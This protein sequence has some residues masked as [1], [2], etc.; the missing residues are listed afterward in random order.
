MPAQRMNQY[1]HE[2]SGGMKQRVMIAM[3]LACDPKLL[4]C[5]EPT[6][7]LDVTIQKQIL[8][9]IMRLQ[10]RA[11][12]GRALHHARPG[13]DRGDHRHRG[14][15]VSGRDAPEV[16]RGHGHGERA[17]LRPR[18]PHRRVRKRPAASSRTRSTPT[19]RVWCAAARRSSRAR[20]ACRRS[21]TSCGPRSRASPSTPA[22]RTSNIDYPGKADDASARTSPA[23]ARPLLELKDV[24]TW[25]PIQAGVFQR[26]VDWVKAVDGVDLDDHP[27]A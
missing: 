10:K 3:A 19:P 26:T 7:A 5:D 27:R 8:D 13:R 22:I 2:L 4:I 12:H 16:L 17:G 15:H 18:R 24:R 14:G 9:L 20:S 23:S 11:Q 6:T 1:P 25:F 21:T